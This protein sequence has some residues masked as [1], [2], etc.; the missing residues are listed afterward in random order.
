VECA[1]KAKQC[2][3]R[4]SINLVKYRGHINSTLKKIDKE[5]E[6]YLVVCTGHQGEPGSILDRIMR[7]QTPFNFRPKDN[8]I[9]SS[10]VIPVEINIAA[11]EKMDK[12]LRKQ[13]VRL[14]KDIHVS[15]HLSSEDHRDFI[16]MLKPKYIIPT[17]GTHAQ[18][19]PLIDIAKEFGYKFGETSYLVKDGQV[20]K[21][22]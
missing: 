12:K 22:D 21:F 2:S 17:H 19:R 14:Q 20:L 15:G 11:R 13:G 6:K 18:E 4:Q 7:G 1:V 8:L 9:F 16:E 5:R 10:S 3:F